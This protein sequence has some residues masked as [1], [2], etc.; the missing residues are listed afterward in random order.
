MAKLSPDDFDDLAIDCLSFELDA[1]VGNFATDERFSNLATLGEL[2]K[3]L[4]RTN[5]YKSCPTFFKLLKLALILPISTATVERVFSAMK[6]I[7]TDLRNKM[8]DEF[9]SDAIVTYFECDLFHSLSNDDI[10]RRFQN[11]KTRRAHFP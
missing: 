4:V 1:F 7:K 2:F 6:F 3:M 10:M 5:L 11:M 8:R 9:L